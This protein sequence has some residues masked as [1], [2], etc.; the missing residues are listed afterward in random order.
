MEKQKRMPCPICKLEEQ[1]VWV[2]NGGERLSLNCPCCGPFTITR[3]AAATA[4]RKGL[5]PKLSAWIR[6]QSESGIPVPEINAKMLEELEAKLPTYKVAEKHIHLLRALERRTA[7]PGQAVA[8]VLRFDYP[9]AWAAG[10]EELI[11]LLRSLIERNLARRT[12]GP[13][14]L[15]DSFAFKF[16][17]TSDGWAFV[18]DAQLGAQSKS[19]GFLDQVYNEVNNYFKGHSEDVY[20]KL[21]KAAQLIG[22]SD[23]EDLSL[24]LTQVRRAIKSA[25][26]YFYP[27][28]DALVK[29]ADGKERQ[30]GDEQYL[31]RLQEYLATA[32]EQSSSRDLLRAEL[33]H[34]A[35]FA[36]RLN[37]VASKGIH[38]DV[39]AREAKQ[40]LLGLYMFLYNVISHLQ[41]KSS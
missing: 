26:D 11:Y 27:T 28:K 40:G 12:D 17:I 15:N 7:S 20:T 34:L 5:G 6:E 38:S 8:V 22:S 41:E 13:S 14:D 16:E 39:S 24:L 29:C 33:D 37:E 32:F 31:N 21:Q 4:E 10:E 2:F 9:L 19:E 25:A 35:V 23:P 3:T 18:Q 30:L 36:R 1:D